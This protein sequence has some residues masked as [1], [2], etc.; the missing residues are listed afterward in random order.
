MKKIILFLIFSLFLFSCSKDVSLPEQKYFQTGSVFSGS[1]DDYNTY[2]GYLS[3]VDS[4]P[5]STKIGGRVTSVFV[6]EGDYV[7]AGDLLLTLDSMEARVGYDT[8]SNILNN[9]SELKNTTSLMF[10]DQIKALNEKL[11]QVILGESGINTGLSDI[12]LVSEAQLETALTGLETAKTNLENTK[13]LLDQKGKN[14]IDNSKNA[15]VSSVMLDTNII[16]FIDEILGVT[17]ANKN[18]NNDYEI[19]LSARNSSI[20]NRSKIQFLETNKL[21]LDYKKLYNTEI[22]NKNPSEEIL[23]KALNDGEIL[24]E[25]IKVLLNLTYDVL[26]NSVENVYLPKQTIDSFKQTITN[27]GAQI[28]ASLITVS[29]E[30][31]LGLKGS[32]QSLDDFENTKNLQI[33]MLEKQVELAEKNYNQYKL[34]SD[35]KIRETQTQTKVV[36]SQVEELKVNIESLK[37]QKQAKLEEL[38]LKITE[39]LGQRDSAGVMINSGEIRSPISGVITSKMVEVGQVI[40][41]GMPVFIVS[42]ES[43]L[44]L[45][46]LVGED[47]LKNIDLGSEV[48]LEVDGYDKQLKAK[49]SLI[50]PSKEELT[51]K[52]KVEVILKNTFG[53]KIGSYTKVYLS[54]V[55][56]FDFTLIPNNS[57]VSKYMIPG[58]Y[59][60]NNDGIVRFKNIEI[61]KSNDKFS[62]ISGLKVGEIVITY[63]K[64]NIFDGEKLR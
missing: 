20:Y 31:F 4:V 24:A 58:V 50:Y 5:L 29:G 56:N 43:N 46:I 37:K 55:D 32:K 28:E 60:L 49:V 23:L 13:I 30:Y 1:I 36:S 33:S 52:T 40:G 59:V 34:A 17:E 14:I 45:D 7:R 12:K 19:Y 44:K 22:E 47:S 8:S 10:D 26:E 61:I 35:S 57:I 3:G 6:S 18:K 63:G 9:L 25:S 16:N 51:K 42:D 62:H 2:V 48:L 27:F 53:L 21:Y 41:G 15:I 64:E 54:S 11:N 39:S 38:D